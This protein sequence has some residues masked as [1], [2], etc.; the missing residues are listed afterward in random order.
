MFGPSAKGKLYFLLGLVLA[1][2]PSLAEAR[3]HNFANKSPFGLGFKAGLEKN[4]KSDFVVFPQTSASSYGKFYAFEPFFDFGNFALRGS[5]S[6]HPHPLLSGS[7]SDTNGTFGE[8]S[9]ASSVAFGLQLLLVPFYSQDL[10][11]RFSSQCFSSFH[12]LS[13]RKRP[14]RRQ[15]AAGFWTKPTQQFQVLTSP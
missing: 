11:Q 7:G 9:D 12:S 14:I 10:S 2:A 5:A 8:T 6:L 1:L 3:A 13:Q 4:P 15:F